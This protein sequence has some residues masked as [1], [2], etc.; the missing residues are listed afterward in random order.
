MNPKLNGCK[1]EHDLARRIA[2]TDDC[3]DLIHFW[4]YP[5]EEHSVTTQDGYS[6]KLFRIPESRHGITAYS[7]PKPYSRKSVLLWHGLALSSDVFVCHP[8]PDLNL[9]F[10]LADAGFDVW[11]GNSRG[12]KYS[13]KHVSR[14]PSSIDFWDFSIDELAQYDVPDSCAYILGVT[15][16]QKLSYI[17]FSQGSTQAF[18]ALSLS[19]ELNRSIDLFIA[20]APAIKPAPLNNG[21]IRMLTNTFT[22]HAL[23]PIL[24]SGPFMP[25]VPFVNKTVPF[26]VFVN[27]I[28]T[29][30]KI[31]FGWHCDKFG[32]ESRKIAL[33]SHIFSP[34]SM[35]TIVHWFQIIDDGRFHMYN[36]HSCPKQILLRRVRMDPTNQEP[37]I[38]P[39]VFPT[40]HISTKMFLFHGEC[41]KISDPVFLR[42]NLPPHTR[43]YQVPGYEHM[44]FLWATDAR[45]RVW[46]HVIQVLGQ[47]DQDQITYDPAS[48][49]SDQTAPVVRSAQEEILDLEDVELMTDK[50]TEDAA[51]GV[52]AILHDGDTS[53]HIAAAAESDFSVVATLPTYVLDPMPVPLVVAPRIENGASPP[54]S[55]CGSLSQPLPPV[56]E[57]AGEGTSGIPFSYGT[58]RRRG[59]WRR[60]SGAVAGLSGEELEERLNGLV[61]GEVGSR[62]CSMGYVNGVGSGSG[63]NGVGIGGGGGAIEVVEVVEE[64]EEEEIVEEEVV[65][66]IVEEQVVVG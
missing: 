60:G 34:S 39:L 16:R 57:D 56:P 54:K 27:S 29:T 58:A 25:F 46:D 64:Y 44:D 15:G 12:N 55:R 26:R 6:I 9:A 24:G 7:A 8:D 17:G 37:S 63:V 49:Q 4:D 1:S 14:D 66:E 61:A 36:K 13:N 18:A 20:L 38:P 35:K 28:D 19:N 50:P 2:L 22:P 30:F 33:Y 32:P 47:A 42:A 10:L 52:G 5:C 21:A 53:S 43:M 65:E 48:W 59:S 62:S 45:T 31:L 11:L 51:E 23:Y 3:R 41:D 40:Q